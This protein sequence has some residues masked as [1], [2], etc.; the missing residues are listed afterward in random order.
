MVRFSP[1]FSIGIKIFGI[2]T[3]MLVF[4]VVIVGINY[5]RIKKVNNELI[6]LSKYSTPLT[7]HLN[8]INIRVLKQQIHLE[9]ILQLY[10]SEPVN[11]PQIE[12]EFAE[13]EQ[14]GKRVDEEVDSAIALSYDALSHAKLI[15]DIIQVA[16]LKP[17]LY[18]LE[19][20][21]QEFHNRGLQI[22][23]SL[24]TGN[25]TLINFLENELQEEEEQ[26]NR[27]IQGVF[28]ELGIFIQDSARNADREERAILN[29]NIILISLATG[30]GILSA[31]TLTAGLVNPLKKLIGSTKEVEGGNLDIQVAIAS[32]DEIETLAD[33]F[34]LMV[35]EIKE[36]EQIQ[37][38]FGQYVDPRI[39]ENL[40]QQKSK[41]SFGEKQN[42]TVF[43]SDVVGF[44]AISEMLAPEGLV[45]L[46]NQ[47]FYPCCRTD[48]T[49]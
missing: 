16:R 47:Y 19:E 48:R 34:N 40:I 28:Q 17:L 23:Q 3:S 9:R 2:A 6:D 30:F 14:Q 4:L 37:N 43:F 7:T 31:F 26:F 38:T 45:K 36:K 11:W 10:E 27:Q 33:A 39:V 8:T 44:T 42:V 13:F 22:I 29:L 15:R 1:K 24:Q 25:S 35:E 18:N 32:G 21:H 46:L 12:Q 20:E 5:D 49:L 41:Q